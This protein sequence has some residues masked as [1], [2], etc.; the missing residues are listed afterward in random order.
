MHKIKIALLTGGDSSEYEISLKSAEEIRSH[1]DESLYSVFLIYVRDNEWCYRS[2]GR[3]IMVDKNDFSLLLGAKRVRFDLVFMAIH[4]T[5]GEDGKLQS[6][7][8]MLGIPF[9]SCNSFT[10][11]L[12]FNKYFCVNVV[13]SIGVKCAPGV[14]LYAHQSLDEKAILAVTGL[15][16]FVKP[17]KGGSSVGMS[18]VTEAHALAR[19]VQRA[20]EE[21]D[22]VLVESFIGGREFTCGVYREG[23]TLRILPL[24]EIV[25]RKD[26]FDF[27]AKYDPSLTREI[28]SPSIGNNLEVKIKET[29]A[30]L[31]ERLHC[32]GIVRFDYIVDAN[33]EVWFLEVN[34][35]PGMT[36][37][38]LVPK[39]IRESGISMKT[40]YTSLVNHTLSNP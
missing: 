24:V 7:F 32:A 38:S 1:L 6:Y 2:E 4:G 29:S 25:T 23:S 8:E 22:E 3:T 30:L 35:V 20:F 39:M 9:T 31:Y 10:A 17:N 28:V 36:K 34:T 15:P 13:R 14:I 16:C 18:K 5:P 26:F 33:D 21:D 11:S 12:T 19:A 27:E 37:E 40:F